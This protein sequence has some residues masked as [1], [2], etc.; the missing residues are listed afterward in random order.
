MINKKGG[1]RHNKGSK[2]LSLGLR[3]QKEIKG[4][5]RSDMT[6]RRGAL[7]GVGVR[8]AVVKFNTQMIDH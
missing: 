4:M 2:R 1:L 5:R 7:L 6:H 3:S 8:G